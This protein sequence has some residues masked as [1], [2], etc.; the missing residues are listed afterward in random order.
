[1]NY[2]IHSPDQ[3]LTN[4]NPSFSGICNWGWEAVNHLLSSVCRDEN[5][6]LYRERGR[7]ICLRNKDMRWRVRVPW[8]PQGFALPAR[9]ISCLF[10]CI[11][12]IWF[13]LLNVT[14]RTL[15]NSEGKPNIK[16]G[17]AGERLLNQPA[18]KQ[19]WSRRAEGPRDPVQPS[20]P[21]SDLS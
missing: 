18:A 19:K 3:S 21:P 15:T 16:R 17:K 10:A 1:M 20:C 7:P 4:Q 9:L 5:V 11:G 6:R 13:L 12:S 14:Q 2:G 8:I